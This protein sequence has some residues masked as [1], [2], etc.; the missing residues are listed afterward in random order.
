MVS[1]Q[2]LCC[3]Q[4][5]GGKLHVCSRYQVDEQ[6]FHFLSLGESEGPQWHS[7]LCSVCRC[8][9]RLLNNCFHVWS[10][11]TLNALSCSSPFSLLLRQVHS[12][13]AYRVHRYK[14]SWFFLDSI[15]PLYLAMDVLGSDVGCRS[16]NPSLIFKISI[17]LRWAP[18]GDQCL[19]CL[20]HPPAPS[21]SSCR[22]Q[23]ATQFLRLGYPVNRIWEQTST[24]E[25]C[26]ATSNHASRNP[27][28]YNRK[29]MWGTILKGKLISFTTLKMQ[30]ILK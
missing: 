6:V 2:Y 9:W 3:E 28:L 10:C 4:E 30:R 26:V 12:V 14:G 13:K 21:N 7:L 24:K 15:F 18:L 8:P 5:S 19:W 22:P 29:H 23:T 11:S 25:T 27:D 16:S 17:A 20:Y 1:E